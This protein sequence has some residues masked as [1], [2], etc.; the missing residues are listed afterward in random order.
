LTANTNKSTTTA[1]VSQKQLNK[2]SRFLSLVLRHKPEVIGLTLDSHG[3][4]SISELI[5]KGSSKLTLTND[6][7]KQVVTTNDKQR[8]TLA[9]DEQR[10]R[11]NQGHSIKVDLDLTAKKPPSILYHGTAT[12]FLS[13]IQKEGLRRGQR[14]HVHLSTDTKTATAVG[15]R[16]GEP[17]VLQIATGEMLQAGYEFFLSE[18]GV[19]L[20]EHVPPQFLTIAN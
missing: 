10:I 16:Y 9:K 2:I 12:R 1:P 5:E 17:V 11:A 19:W 14:H 8:F 15:Q 4:A 6:L 18:N 13:S 7:I 3:W 20:T